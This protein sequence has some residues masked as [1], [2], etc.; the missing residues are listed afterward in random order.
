MQHTG[1]K[2]LTIYLQVMLQSM[3]ICGDI[4]KNEMPISIYFF[5]MPHVVSLFSLFLLIPGFKP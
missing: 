1:Q 2:I 5:E 4:S 3:Q